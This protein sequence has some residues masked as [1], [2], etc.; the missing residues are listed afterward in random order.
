MVDK[1]NNV[2]LDTI[3]N[4]NAQLKEYIRNTDN[5]S[6]SAAGFYASQT[7]SAAGFLGS[8]QAIKTYNNIS[9]NNVILKPSFRLAQ[10][11]ENVRRFRNLLC[12]GAILVM[13]QFTM[14][15]VRYVIKKEEEWELMQDRCSRTQDC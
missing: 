5:A 10:T 8:I 11:A 4:L 7:K 9:A 13:S 1:K 14:K 6:V 3:P 15:L 12:S 2:D